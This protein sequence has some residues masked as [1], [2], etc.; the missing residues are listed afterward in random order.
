MAIKTV[1]V[2]D[3]P[4]VR[5]GVKQM[6]SASEN[7]EVVAEMEDVDARF[8]NLRDSNLCHSIM[9]CCNFTQADLSN[10]SMIHASLLHSNF[11]DACMEGCL[12]TDGKPWGFGNP[13]KSDSTRPFWQ[14]WKRA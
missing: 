4:V 14:F 10:S 12:G 1:I 13:K 2:D 7:I 11:R 5:F 6:L 9:S 3:H 8:A